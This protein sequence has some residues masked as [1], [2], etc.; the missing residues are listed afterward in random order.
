MAN[1]RLEKVE[2]AVKHHPDP[3][4]SASEVTEAL[5]IDVTRRTVLDDLRLLERA[6]AVESKEIG[7]RA[8][9]W[10]HVDRVNPAPPR[11][12]ADHPDQRDLEDAAEPVDAIAVD[13]EQERG[14]ADG[15]LEDDRIDADDV[16][17]GLDLPG[18]GTKLERRRDAVRACVDFVR[19][20]G[21]ATKSDFIDAHYADGDGEHVA[22]FGSSGGWWNAIG[23]QGL[24]EVAE[25]VDALEP[26][27]GEGAHRWEWTA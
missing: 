25:H 7:A 6:D 3:V 4:V 19:D 21:A 22:G 26:P 2:K 11:D 8:V 27:G 20:H 15:G 1:D 16:I 12:P 24:Q 18:S 23:K 5:E 13:A 9:A 14:D 17:D 10:V